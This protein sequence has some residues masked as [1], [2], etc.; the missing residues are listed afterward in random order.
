MKNPFLIPLA[1]LGYRSSQVS[2]GYDGDNVKVRTNQTQNYY[3]PRF[4]NAVGLNGN[5]NN[6]ADTIRVI[7]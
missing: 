7:L 2:I 3:L 6:L 5:H 4:Y 1:A